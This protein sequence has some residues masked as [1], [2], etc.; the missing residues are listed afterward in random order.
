MLKRYSRYHVLETTYG[1]IIYVN[2][3]IVKII[4]QGKERFL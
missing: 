4:P 2:K 1:P 3:R